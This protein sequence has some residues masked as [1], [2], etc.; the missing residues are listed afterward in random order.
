MGYHGQGRFG[1]AVFP[2]NTDVTK[3]TTNPFRRE[4]IF[5]GDRIVFPQKDIYIYI[6]VWYHVFGEYWALRRN[7]AHFVRYFHH[8]PAEFIYFN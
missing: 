6:F 8:N 1:E 4:G 7:N 5:G 2:L 3:A